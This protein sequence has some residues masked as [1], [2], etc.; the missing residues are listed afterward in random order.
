LGAGPHT[1]AVRATTTSGDSE[2]TSASV[3]VKVDRHLSALP[4][5]TFYRTVR[6]ADIRRVSSY[7]DAAHGGFGEVPPTGRWGLRVRRDG[8]MVIGYVHDD[9]WE[10]FPLQTRSDRLTIYGPAVW[11]QPHPDQPSLFCDPE[12]PATYRWATKGNDLAITAVAHT[13]ADRDEVPLGTWHRS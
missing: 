12:P 4:T 5:G 9:N 11:L 13:C 1:L 10:Y 3:V 6:D 8:V 2:E 7:R